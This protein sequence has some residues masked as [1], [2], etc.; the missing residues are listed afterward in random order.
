MPSSPA[1]ASTGGDDKTNL[2]RNAIPR[3]VPGTTDVTEY[4]K[5]LEFLASIWPEEH[6]RALAPR[7]ALLCEGTAFKKIAR[8]SP[9]KLKASDTSGVKLMLTTLGGAW[10]QTVLEAKYEQF[11]KAIYGTSQRNDETNDSYLARQDV[12][13]E[14]LL[15]QKVTLEKIRAYILWR[16]LQLSSEDT[17]KIVIEHGGK[18][19]YDNV[20]KSIRMLGSRFFGE[21]LQGKPGL[22]RNRIYDVNFAEDENTTIEESSG[23]R[24]FAAQASSSTDEGDLDLD[25]EFVDALVAAEDADALQVSSFES[26]LE[27]FS[28]RLQ[29]CSRP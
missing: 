29:S 13:F 3:F 15:T 2:P 16:Q 1:E 21:F 11:E 6:V 20:C 22:T 4:G 24:A 26:E 28:R 10:G 9:D 7:V 23:E 12:H 5:T 19:D 17:K 27:S 8:L 14:E 18:L 25:Q